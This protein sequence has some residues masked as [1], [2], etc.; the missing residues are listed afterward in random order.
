MNWQPRKTDLERIAEFE[1]S[2]MGLEFAARFLGCTS[3]ELKAWRMKCVEAA[4]TEYIKAIAAPPLVPVA[5][6]AFK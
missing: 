5:K 3:E 4:R 6:P 2:G 1:I